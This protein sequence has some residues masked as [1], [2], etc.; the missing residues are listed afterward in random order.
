MSVTL[1][2]KNARHLWLREE[3]ME[4]IV[5]SGVGVIALLAA[6]ILADARHA[7]R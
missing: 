5:L 1:H 4:L 3:P 7:L 6:N 2:R